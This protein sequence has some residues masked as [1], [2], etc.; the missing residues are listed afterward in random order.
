MVT[1]FMISGKMA[2]PGLRKIK[3][4]L[5]KG[6]EVI[7]FVNGI[8]NNILSRESNYIVYL[9]PWPRF[10][11]SIYH[12]LKF[13]RIWPENTTFLEGCYW[14]KF[15]N[16]R[17]TLGMNLKYDTSMAK[18]LKLKVRTILAL[19]PAFAEVT[20]YLISKNVYIDKLNDIVSKYN[21][22]Y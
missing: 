1:I 9:V 4:F 12:N 19:I 6:Y 16:L 11:N 10:R 17:M 21:N 15:T 2:T 8:N 7:M 5:K 22:T 20:G 18:G 3:I 13:I 14:F